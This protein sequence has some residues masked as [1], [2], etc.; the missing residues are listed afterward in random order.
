MIRTARTLAIAVAAVAAVATGT[1][2]GTPDAQAAAPGATAG[3]PTTA[4]SMA[5]GCRVVVVRTTS[6]GTRRVYRCD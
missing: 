2:A 1:A 4:R 6:G 5:S 3:N